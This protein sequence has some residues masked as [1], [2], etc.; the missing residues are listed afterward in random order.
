[1]KHCT[2]INQIH[3][4]YARIKVAVGDALRRFR[5]LSKRLNNKDMKF[6]GTLLGKSLPSCIVSFSKFLML[7]IIIWIILNS[8]LK[9]DLQ[10]FLFA[11]KSL[12]ETLRKSWSEISFNCS[13][14]LKVRYKSLHQHL[15]QESRQQFSCKLNYWKHR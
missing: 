15:A 13:I 6:I 4:T 5:I 1:M 10:Y 8:T 11:C 3:H 14:P 9:A 2:N 7:C 12:S